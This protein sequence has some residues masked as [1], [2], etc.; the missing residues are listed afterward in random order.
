MMSFNFSSIESP[1]VG[2]RL[3]FPPEKLEKGY[4][5]YTLD[6][7]SGRLTAEFIGIDGSTPATVLRDVWR[8]Q[9]SAVVLDAGCGTGYQLYSLI[10]QANLR[11]DVDP[12]T[13]VAHGVSD[14]DFSTRSQVAKV[15][16]AIQAGR[17]SYTVGDLNDEY[18]LEPDF[19]HLAYSYEVLPHNKK[20]IRIV[21]NIFD[22]LCPGG[23]AFFNADTTQESELI[24]GLQEMVDDNQGDFDYITSPPPLGSLFD[25][26]MGLDVGRCAFKLVKAA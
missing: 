1:T 26:Q 15:R 20:P 21:R 10:E 22:A 18:L 11:L 8:E 24:S 9:G 13:V 19:Y 17:I 4:A 12:G 6:R 7:D 14:H 5:P 23:V 25:R 16:S 2:E 3:Y